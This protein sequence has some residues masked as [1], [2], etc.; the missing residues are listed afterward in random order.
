MLAANLRKAGV[1]EDFLRHQTDGPN[2]L[3]VIERAHTQIIKSYLA[4]HRESRQQ[5]HS[6]A[7]C[8]HADDGG[9]TRSSELMVLRFGTKAELESLFAKA[10]FVVEHHHGCSAQLGSLGGCAFRHEWISRRGNQDKWVLCDYL[11]LDIADFRFQR[12]QSRR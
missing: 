4:A 10:M 7:A 5:C 12:Q 2:R 1:S 6:R 8:D 3:G 11:A 9:E